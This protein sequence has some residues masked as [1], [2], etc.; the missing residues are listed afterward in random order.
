M[1]GEEKIVPVSST[2][3]LSALIENKDIT[4][5]AEQEQDEEVVPEETPEVVDD[6]VLENAFNGPL[7]KEQLL[8]Q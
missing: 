8:N 2:D 7:T 6:D 5:Q 1:N 3:V 4:E